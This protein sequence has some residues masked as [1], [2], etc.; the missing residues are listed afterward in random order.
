MSLDHVEFLGTIKK[1]VKPRTYLEIGV[2][3]GDTLLS[4]PIPDYVVGIDPNP[5]FTGATLEKMRGAK[6]LLLMK[7]TSDDAFEQLH[8]QE[9][10]GS[11]KADMVFVDGLHHAEV[12]LRDIANSAQIAR[13][14]AVICIHDV[15][16][17]SDREAARDPIPEAWM[18]DVYKIV[19]FFWS[20][21]P[22]VPS[23]LVEDV[24][25][26]GMFI[27]RNTADLRRQILDRY[28]RFLAEMEKFSFPATVDDMRTRAVSRTS[29][30]FAQ[31]LQQSVS[32]PA[33]EFA[34]VL[35]RALL[36]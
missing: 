21:L 15:F 30:E 32:E 2:A 1:I 34:R 11:R 10:M 22:A 9:L 31:F 8:S 4:Q 24:P 14:A 28:D 3:A 16:P 18:G 27:L 17:G 25:P 29:P 26:S 36:Q 12:V 23:I 7:A 5:D 6:S 19:P 13:E 20:H 35:I 33:E